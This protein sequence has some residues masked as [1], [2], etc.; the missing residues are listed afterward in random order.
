MAELGQSG[1]YLESLGARVHD[2]VTV[3]AGNEDAIWAPMSLPSTRPGLA[4]TTAL[5]LSLAA[6]IELWKQESERGEGELLLAFTVATPESADSESVR[7]RFEEPR[8]VLALLPG[9]L[10]A[11][12][13]VSDTIVALGSE[14]GAPCSRTYAFRGSGCSGIR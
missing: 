2:A 12:L 10:V 5:A 9:S 1:E 14:L 11:L 7:L 6:G 4:P 8:T 3:A 13:I